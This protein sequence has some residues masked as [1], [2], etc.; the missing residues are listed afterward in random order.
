M[1]DGSN[2]SFYNPD[3]E[4]DPNLWKGI[5]WQ[6]NFQTGDVTRGLSLL[7]SPLIEWAISSFVFNW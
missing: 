2:E 3:E 4:L 5:P 7:M 1:V 6:K